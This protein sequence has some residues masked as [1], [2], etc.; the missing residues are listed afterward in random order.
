MGC[1]NVSGDGSVGGV[2][3]VTKEEWMDWV[4]RHGVVEFNYLGRNYTFL[5]KDVI[6]M[7]GKLNELQKE[8]RCLLMR[9]EDAED[10][11]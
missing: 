4:N 2:K 6:E 11:E 10:D 5:Q 8:V 3:P 1:V 9:L 7:Y